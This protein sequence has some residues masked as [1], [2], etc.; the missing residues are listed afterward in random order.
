MRYIDDRKYRGERWSIRKTAR[1]RDHVAPEAQEE[2]TALAAERHVLLLVGI[3]LPHV[4]RGDA[5]VIDV[6]RTR[7]A[8]VGG[9][10]NHHGS[11]ALTPHQE[12]VP[13]LRGPLAGRLQDLEH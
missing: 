12:R 5:E 4:A 9:D 8:L 11:L 10:Q 6:E 3:V 2:V 13:V 1:V 7:Q